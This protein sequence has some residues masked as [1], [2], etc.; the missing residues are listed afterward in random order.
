MNDQL[1]TTHLQELSAWFTREKH[2]HGLVEMTFC[3][4]SDR[5]VAREEAA[6]VALAMLKYVPA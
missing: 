4:G 3:P 5:E 1:P 6:K 2:D